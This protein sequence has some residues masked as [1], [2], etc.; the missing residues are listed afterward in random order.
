MLDRMSMR[1]LLVMVVLGSTGIQGRNGRQRRRLTGRGHVRVQVGRCVAAVR[2]A[3]A[4]RMSVTVSLAVTVAVGVTATWRGSRVDGRHGKEVLA[5][6]FATNVA[7]T[8]GTTTATA[9]VPLQ[10]RERCGRSCHSGRRRRSLPGQ[11]GKGASRG[12]LHARLARSAA[13]ASATWCPTTTTT[14]EWRTQGP[15]D[16]T[17]SVQLLLVRRVVVVDR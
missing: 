1:V 7:A 15:N 11:T 16:A 2:V 10:R 14:V 6:P 5:R 9:G 12:V 8:Y 17:M 3:M 4:R 13:T